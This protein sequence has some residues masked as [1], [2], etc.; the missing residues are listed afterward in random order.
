MNLSELS[1]KLNTLSDAS[2]V[3]DIQRYV[4]DMMKTKGFNN[5]PLELFCYLNEEVGEL[6]REIRKSEDD[7]ELDKSK[8]YDSKIGL[9]LADIFIYLLAL[10]NAYDV[11]LFKSFILKEKINLGRE[12]E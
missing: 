10:S 2:N 9:E 1:N 5:T 7:M 6:A 12:W 3:S 8:V 4:A 11:D